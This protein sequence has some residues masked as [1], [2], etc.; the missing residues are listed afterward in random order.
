MT[1]RSCSARIIVPIPSKAVVVHHRPVGRRRRR[2]TK[3]SCGVDE[4]ARGGRR[5]R[6]SWSTAACLAS[7]EGWTRPSMARPGDRAPVA[8]GAIPGDGVQLPG[9]G[10]RRERVLPHPRCP[11][12]L[13]PAAHRSRRQRARAPLVDQLD[14]LAHL[15]AARRRDTPR[16][17]THPHSHLVRR[18]DGG[19]PAQTG[20]TE[21]WFGAPPSGRS[22]PPRWPWPSEDGGLDWDAQPGEDAVPP[23][24]AAAHAAMLGHQ[25]HG[26][27]R[28]VQ[29]AAGPAAA[30]ARSWSVESHAAGSL[31]GDP[32]PHRAAV[33][34]DHPRRPAMAPSRPAS[35]RQHVA[36]RV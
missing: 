25:G 9:G 35:L 4:H 13:A 31:A 5:A 20:S 10:G 27:F 23:L 29:L 3:G 19:P 16:L 24:G 6:R 2:G 34:A 15:H 17:P 30:S 18:A 36:E 33:G 32:A 11:G 21:R 14:G 1:D 26:L 28:R 22:A 12:P 8:G 7:R